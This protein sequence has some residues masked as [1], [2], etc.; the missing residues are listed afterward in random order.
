MLKT[1]KYRVTTVTNAVDALQ[2]IRSPDHSF[3]L[4]LTDLHMPCMDGIELMKQVEEEFDLPVVLMSADDNESKVTMGMECGAS[5]YIIKP[6][7]K[8]D[9]QKLWQFAIAKR[10][11]KAIAIDRRDEGIRSRFQPLS[12]TSNYLVLSSSSE[13]TTKQHRNYTKRSTDPSKKLHTTANGYKQRKS[14]TTAAK[15]KKFRAYWRRV[16]YI[17]SCNPNDR[18]TR[19]LSERALKSSFACGL[20]QDVIDRLRRQSQRFQDHQYFVRPHANTSGPFNEQNLGIRRTIPSQP[21]QENHGS[22]TTSQVRHG[23]SNLLTNRGA[24]SLNNIHH[25]GMS[26]LM[27]NNVTSLPASQQ[28]GLVARPPIF[29]NG[30]F[31][32]NGEDLKGLSNQTGFMNGGVL[33]NGM[34]NVPKAPTPVGD[35]S[36]SH[37]AQDAI[38]FSSPPMQPG[39]TISSGSFR[40]EENNFGA[41]PS[42]SAPQDIDVFGDEDEDFLA[43]LTLDL[44]ATEN[45]EG[46]A[47]K[48]PEGHVKTYQVGDNPSRIEQS[49]N[50]VKFSKSAL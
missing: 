48:D 46:E 28:Q 7:K 23:Q 43:W 8:F 44:S 35:S 16:T 5:M 4:V 18:Y 15:P 45:G 26:M 42:L 50:Q 22:N 40:Q 33:P 1:C 36:S 34:T 3:D 19:E 11:S 49:F 2:V 37:L 47:A 30:P 41:A 17:L 32:Y 27:N 12:G 38:V 21:R 14:C 29:S 20:P 9:I 6:V 24:N 39:N 31:Q 25:H 13:G 10:K